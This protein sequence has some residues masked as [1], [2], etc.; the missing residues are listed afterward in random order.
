MLDGVCVVLPCAPSS[1]LTRCALLS[2]RAKSAGG[3]LC[4]A[5]SPT[6][7]DMYTTLALFVHFLLPLAV[8]LQRHRHNPVTHATHHGIQVGVHC[9]AKPFLPHESCPKALLGCLKTGG[10][11]SAFFQGWLSN[12]K[13][14][15]ARYE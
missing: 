6:L 7:V 5:E 12:T 15:L 13:V 8:P 11:F 9:L 14:E 10:R 3:L 1:L 4:P 2:S